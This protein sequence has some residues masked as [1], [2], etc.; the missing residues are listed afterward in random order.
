MMN[1]KLNRIIWC[2]VLLMMTASCTM[3]QG[4]K[5]NEEAE[6]IVKER[7]S[8]IRI[9]AEEGKSLL[10]VDDIPAS[11]ADAVQIVYEPLYDFDEALNP[12]PVLAESIK[13]SGN[14]QYW[15]TLKKDVKWHDGSEF[16][17]NDVIYTFNMLKNSDSV[18][19]DD[20][21]KI[22][23]IDYSNKHKVLITLTE[24]VVNFVGVLSFPIVKRNS[25][26]EGNRNLAPIGTGPYKFSE[27]KNNSYYFVKNSSWHGGDASDKT[28]IITTL[29]DKQSAMYAFEAN[30]GDVISSKIMD[31][32]ENTP[33]GKIKIQNY[34]SNNLTF[35]GMN[36]S[37]GILSRPEIRQA[38][39]Y[40]ID[41]EEIVKNDV[42]GQ[43]VAVNVPIYPGVWFYSA[44]NDMIETKAEENYLEPLL[45]EE[46]WYKKNGIYTKDFGEYEAELTLS[47]LVNKDNSEKTAIAKRIAAILGKSGI[48]V[49]VKAVPYEQYTGRVRSGDFSMFIG[50]MAADKNMDPSKFVKSGRNFFLYSNEEMNS[51]VNRMA[52]ADNNEELIACCSEFVGK[53]NEQMPFVPLFFR[54]EAMI[55][56]SDLA[57]YSTADYYR[58]YKGIENWYFSQK[59]ELSE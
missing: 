28:V 58:P 30:E 42:Y 15:L 39:S 16:V 2:V 23:Q 14:N 55:C 52:R 49:K 36:T 38:I 29:K 46:E 22:D 48:I 13:K 18:F 32:R 5:S 34:T 50:E 40:L 31:L 33:R 3:R 21:K 27:K 45:N 4:G 9:L 25:L 24:P 12:I 20:V 6:I 53:F 51:I 44:Q 43:G 8:E 57:G 7:R 19:A 10:P 54:K 11:L 47:I 59:V 26:S 41:K 17:A 37:E 1:M 56:A 35:L